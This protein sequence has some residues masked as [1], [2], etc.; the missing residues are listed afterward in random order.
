[1]AKEKFSRTKATGSKT[2]Y[3]VMQEMKRRGGSIP[4]KDLYPFVENNVE[5]APWE[6]ERAGKMQYIRWTN[7]FQFYSI[8][9]AKAGFILKKNGMWY[10]TP[11][12]EN[13]IK[14]SANEV[15]N[16]A[17]N[18]YRKWKR[19]NTVE[20]YKDEPSDDA[21]ENANDVKLE[22]LESD[23]RESIKDY[24]TAKDPYQFQDMVA[25]LLRAMGYHT[26]FIAPKG[27]DGGIDII[28]YVDPLGAQTPRIKVQVKHR[29]D[30]VIGASD[31]R[32]LLGVL[33]AGDIA[34]FVTSGTFSSEAKNTSTN[35]REFIRLIDGN[36]FID[37]WQE[38]YDKMSDEDKNMLPLK[39]I[40]FLGKNE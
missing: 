21:Q 19:L 23:A 16:I 40:S 39:R 7:S 26:P 9:Y 11:E 5:L 32:A 30:T 14:K 33:R 20:E 22:Q 17:E 6:C 4:V 1:M 2:L 29:P 12:G 15:M 10:L 8:D 25:A 3:A 24:L 31:I 28:A 34:L 38:Y 37:M 18:A 36:D 27:K 13:V 35:S